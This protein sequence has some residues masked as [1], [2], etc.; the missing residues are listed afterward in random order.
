MATYQSEYETFMLEMHRKHPEWE[1][2]QRD[3]LALLWNK[4][5]NFAEQQAF[6]EAA[7]KQN[8]YPY[9]VNF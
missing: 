3:G 6:R 8:S 1:G 7:E 9:D 2:E 4:K 5:V